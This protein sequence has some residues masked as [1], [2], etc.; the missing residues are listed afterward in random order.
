MPMSNKGLT[1]LTE[2]CGELIQIAAKK[3]AFME[4]DLHPDGKGSMRERLQEELADV[5]AAST[6][7]AQQFGL[8]TE[9]IKQRA[10]LKLHAFQTW[11]DR[12]D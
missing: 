2:E 1:K 7:V 12:A 9:Q 5:A 4:T 10:A 11:H 8:D 6:F 3:I